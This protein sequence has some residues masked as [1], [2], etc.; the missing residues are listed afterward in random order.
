M[1][2]TCHHAS[3]EAQLDCMIH[4]LTFEVGHTNEHQTSMNK[5]HFM[6]ES[7]HVCTNAAVFLVCALG[8]LLLRCR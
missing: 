6:N 8:K 7:I 5:Y 3:G 4:V 2:V 1:S